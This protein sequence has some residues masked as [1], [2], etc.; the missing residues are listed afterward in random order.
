MSLL[1]FKILAAV[2]IWL[3]TIVSAWKPIY[4]HKINC[5]KVSHSIGEAF[6]SGVFL[7][8]GLFHMLPDATLGFKQ[9]F[10]HTTYPLANLLCAL[11]FVILLFL[12]K[13]IF[14]IA[15]LKQHHK[16]NI[17]PLVLTFVLSIHALIEGTAFGIN[18]AIAT[19]LIIFIAIIAH[20]GSESFALATAL[21]KSELSNKR[22][23]V[24]FGLFS[25]MTPLG[26]AFGSIVLDLFKTQ[27]GIL[28]QAIFNSI[29][30]GSFLYI[31]TL[32]H[33]P[34]H[35]HHLEEGLEEN[36]LL[37]FIAVLI[38]LITMAVV[39]IWV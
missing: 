7:G 16:A 4:E 31:A 11:G 33:S 21:A 14:K 18:T 2:F 8:V 28:L 6:A 30:A 29:A 26:I 23:L 22:I 9:I 20:K 1:L 24:V 15:K 39:A 25:L 19:A 38:G 32:H 36:H 3:I 12:E 35:H 10:P 34:E 17:L 37:H 27:N 5:H 13:V